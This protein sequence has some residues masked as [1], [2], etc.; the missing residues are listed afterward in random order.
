RN[1]IELNEEDLDQGLW[2]VSLDPCRSKRWTI[3]DLQHLGETGRISFRSSCTPRTRQNPTH[4]RDLPQMKIVFENIKRL[5]EPLEQ[6]ARESFVFDL[7]ALVGRPGWR[8]VELVIGGAY[9]DMTLAY[10]AMLREQPSQ[11]G[12][13]GVTM[14]IWDRFFGAMKSTQL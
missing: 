14:E 5:M 9:T 3:G 2:S 10:S 11:Q 6:P 8:V 12:G 4:V 13:S 7:Q 1:T